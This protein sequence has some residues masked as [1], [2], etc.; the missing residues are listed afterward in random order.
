MESSTLAFAGQFVRRDRMKFRHAA[1]LALVA[2]YLMIPP[3]NRHANGHLGMPN[4]AVLNDVSA[5]EILSVADSEAA[6]QKA[7]LGI[8]DSAIK[9]LRSN[10]GVSADASGIR[11]A[12]EHTK[13]L[14][15]LDQ[16]ERARLQLD[17]KCV[18]ADDP[19]IKR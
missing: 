14:N 15:Q 12:R 10:F 17:I 9:W 13:N 11:T 1:A 18:S 5:W 2:W 7:R 16:I 4:Q 6:C 19:R 8:Q 3:I